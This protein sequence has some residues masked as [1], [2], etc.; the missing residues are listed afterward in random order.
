FTGRLAGIVAA[1]THHGLTVPV[2]TAPGLQGGWIAPLHPYPGEMAQNFWPAIVAWTTCFLVT[3]GVSLLTKPRQPQEL[4]GLVYSLTERPKEDRLPFIR[5]PAAL[6][7]AVLAA[8]LVLN[9]LF[10]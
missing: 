7:L 5:R 1:A 6:G 9:I 4:V 10:F 2:A 3:I 8:V